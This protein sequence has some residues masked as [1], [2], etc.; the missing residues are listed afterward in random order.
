M[1]RKLFTFLLILALLAGIGFVGYVI[2]TE[3][4]KADEIDPAPIDEVAIE[5]EIVLR[6]EYDEENNSVTITASA[7][8][9]D[10][11]GIVGIIIPN[12]E[13]IPSEEVKIEVTENGEYL[14]KAVGANGEEKTASISV[15]DIS[16]ITYDNPY[17]PEKFSVLEGSTVENGF[18]IADEYGNQFVWIPV[19][20][21]KLS[22]TTSFDTDY[23]ENASS[24]SALV[25][26]VA[27]Y[28]GFYI[29]RFEATEFEVNGT[30]TAASMQGRIPWTNIKYVDAVQYA[31]NAGS[32]YGYE[33]CYTALLS[34]H[35]WDTVLSLLDS[36]YPNYSSSIN[37]GNYS[38]LVRASGT[39]DSDI[40]YQ[41]CDI[42]GNVSE[43]TTE[44]YKKITSEGDKNENKIARVIRGGAA[45]LS[46]TPSSRRGYAEDLLDPFWGFRLILYK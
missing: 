37:F 31:N 41:I 6:Q 8:T 21:G 39:T 30:K 44:R 3:V 27:K 46:R 42:A 11:G 12:G 33:D 35:A 43:W 34:S 22:R 9:E 1:I 45:S 25:N 2:Y 14:F 15:S 7:T 24:A 10:E 18:V 16:E 20:N 4:I 5:P 36:K 38:G 40:V 23:E 28:H 29:G 32:V 19:E 13:N 26:S 17:V